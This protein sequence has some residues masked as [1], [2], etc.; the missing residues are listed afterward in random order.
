MREP[1]E[2]SVVSNERIESDL[3]LL[4]T[5]LDDVK[6]DIFELKADGRSLRE[7]LDATRIELSGRIDQLGTEL[8]DSI[9]LV[10]TELIGSISLARSELINS[11][12]QVRADQNTLQE[13]LETKIEEGDKEL[14]KK[15]EQVDLKLGT[16]IDQLASTVNTT[17]VAVAKVA[18]MQKGL[19]WMIGTLISLLALIPG[20]YMVGAHF[21]WF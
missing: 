18:T 5:G 3:A 11:I 21:H 4:R 17:N 20:L 10:R 12:S 14:G 16:K 7:K 15:I 6:A 9:S 19:I 2:V 1:I 13:K 8:R